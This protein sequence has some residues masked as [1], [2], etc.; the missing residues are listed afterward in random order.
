MFNPAWNTNL[1]GHAYVYRPLLLDVNAP[2]DLRGWDVYALQKAIKHVVPGTIVADGIFGFKTD[3][4][5]KRAQRLLGLHDDGISGPSTNRAFCEKFLRDHH[6][7]GL[8]TEL[9]KGMVEYES[10]FLLGNYS[11]INSDG[12]QDMGVVMRNSK[13]HQPEFAFNPYASIRLLIDTVGARYQEYVGYGV[14]SKDECLRLA[15]GSWNAPSWATRL[16]QGGTLSPF[17][18]EWLERYIGNV[19]KYL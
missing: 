12:S 2:L 1:P 15:A 16:A 17:A 8:P 18:S 6:L 4:K 7:P 14:R 19:T 13:Y 11:A 3:K 9:F 10:S 5:L